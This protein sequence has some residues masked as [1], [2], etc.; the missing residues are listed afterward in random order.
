MP[1]SWQHPLRG[2]AGR[3]APRGG[4]LAIPL[5]PPC[6]FR[7]PGCPPSCLVRLPGGE[8]VMVRPGPMPLPS[9]AIPPA[10]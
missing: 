1:H 9:W 5:N 4:G 6:T 2:A 3:E 8:R 10:A 7:L